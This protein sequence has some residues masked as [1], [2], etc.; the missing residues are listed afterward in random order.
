MPWL[1]FL[2]LL[3]PS[4]VNRLLVAAALP[5]PGLAAVREADPARALA[6]LAPALASLRGLLPGLALLAL[7]GAVWLGS[8]RA[9]AAFNS[10]A[11]GRFLIGAG[12]EPRSVFTWMA[13]R[14]VRRQLLSGL[15]YCWLFLFYFQAFG[16]RWHQVAT[17]SAALVCSAVLLVASRIAA[18]TVGRAIGLPL[19]PL[20]VGLMFLGGLAVAAAWA[21]ALALPAPSGLTRVLASLPPG[22]WLLAALQGEGWAAAALGLAAA[23]ATGAGIAAANDCLPECWAAS[24]RAFEAKRRLRQGRLWG[25][26]PAPAAA[27]TGSSAGW[28]PPGL[29]ALAWKEWLAL[30]R[31]RGGLALYGLVVLAALVLG[32]GLGLGGEHLGKA[33]P[34]VAADLCAVV[35]ILTF[36]SSMQ[37]GADLR[38]PLWWLSADPL[39]QRLAVVTLSRSLRFLLPLVAFLGASTL[40]PGAGQSLAQLALAPVL[41]L[42]LWAVQSLGLASYSVLPAAADLRVAQTLRLAGLYAAVLAV[43]AAA[44]PGLLLRNLYLAVAGAVVVLLAEVAAC[45]AFACWRIEGNGIAFAREERQ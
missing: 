43:A 38:N 40:P 27:P 2:V 37:L 22:S 3:V 34:L 45:T 8:Q 31:S 19:G 35:A 41:G 11:E 24:S 33:T 18:F 30:R 17:A 13:L 5:H 44:V 23:A 1:L 9:P 36:V 20:G 29:W 16:L 10:P 28:V 32:L 6:G 7:G 4:L 21:P 39:W 25:S 14:R 26:S 15:F 12:L 42:G